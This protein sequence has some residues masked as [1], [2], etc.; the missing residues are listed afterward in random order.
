MGQ[1][2]PLPICNLWSRC[3][4]TGGSGRA[5]RCA[6]RCRVG[7]LLLSRGQNYQDLS[8]RPSRPCRAPALTAFPHLCPTL[9]PPSTQ[10][11][12][13]STDLVE[14]SG[15]NTHAHLGSAQL[16][17]PPRK[18]R[19][20]VPVAPPST[21][22]LAGWRGPLSSDA[23]QREEEKRGAAPGSGASLSAC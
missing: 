13:S 9:S 20:C 14:E 15:E 4:Q 7:W 17:Q 12:A 2:P 5:P 11:G 18:E 1:D 10:P 23:P 16:Q 3:S 19:S 6:Q 22:P 8:A 21:S